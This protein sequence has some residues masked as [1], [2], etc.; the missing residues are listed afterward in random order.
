M[1]LTFGGDGSNE[2]DTESQ[3]QIVLNSTL[4]RLSEVQ[5]SE[6]ERIVQ[7]GHLVCCIFSCQSSKFFVHILCDILPCRRLEQIGNIRVEE[8]VVGKV[9]SG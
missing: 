7:A 4:G 8:R 3:Q 5:L 9:G 2:N 1:W 6:V